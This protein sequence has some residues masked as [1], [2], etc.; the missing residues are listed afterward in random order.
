MEGAGPQLGRQSCRPC[1]RALHVQPRH[2]QARRTNEFQWSVTARA[3][4]SLLLVGFTPCTSNCLV[5]LRSVWTSAA[6]ESAESAVQQPRAALLA[7]VSA[8]KCVAQSKIRKLRVR[9]AVS[10]CCAASDSPGCRQWQPG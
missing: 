3:M 10:N 9:F 5:Y 4:S 2:S 7:T 6:G 8:V 1:T